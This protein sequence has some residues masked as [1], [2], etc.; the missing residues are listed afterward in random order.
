LALYGA[1]N[2]L[3]LLALVALNRDVERLGLA[4]DAEPNDYA[5][6]WETWLTLA[7]FTLSIPAAFVL[8]RHGPWFLILLAVPN[9]IGWLRRLFSRRRA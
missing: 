9:R 3:A 5:H 7:V 6:R 4:G 2:A 8:G 1:A